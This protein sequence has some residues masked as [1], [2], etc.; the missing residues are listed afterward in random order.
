MKSTSEFQHFAE[1]VLIH[2]ASG[3]VGISA[4]CSSGASIDQE[5]PAANVSMAIVSVPPVSCSEICNKIETKFDFFDFLIFF[6]I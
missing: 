1:T 5:V 6:E 3:S 4:F 2:G